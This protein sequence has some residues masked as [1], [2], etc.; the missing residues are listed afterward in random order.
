MSPYTYQIKNV[1]KNECIIVIKYISHNIESFAH[2]AL[3]LLIVSCF[4]SCQDEIPGIDALNH[5][6]IC[7]SINNKDLESRSNGADST[8]HQ[9]TSSRYAGYI[10]LQGESDSLFIHTTIEDEITEQ[11][12]LEEANTSE[13]A[14]ASR[15]TPI[16]S[17][18]TLNDFHVLAYW[19]KDE[20]LMST[21][22]MNDKITKSGALWSSTKSYYWPGTNHKL[23]FFAVAPEGADGLTLPTTP[24]STVLSY[25]VPNDV[26]KQQDLMFSTHDS[27]DGGYINGDYNAQVPLN[28][29]KH[30][31][32]AV[33]FSVGNIDGKIHSISIKGIRNKGT[34][35]MESTP[36]SEDWKWTLDETST[37]D[38]TLKLEYTIPDD[39]TEGTSITSDEK[40]LMM[41][42]QQL[43][44]EAKIEVIYTDKKYGIKRTL[45]ANI[46]N[47]NWEIG[48]YINYK[49]TSSE[50]LATPYFTATNPSQL[51]YTG[52]RSSYSVTSYIEVNGEKRATSWS[53]K[54]VRELNDGTY[55]T[56]NPG[57]NDYPTWIT[58]FDNKGNGSTT[59]LYY[60]V[61]IHA[62][63]AKAP[64]N[65]ILKITQPVSGTYNLSNSTG[66]ETVEKTAN[67]YIINAPGKYS[68]PLVYGNAIDKT[69]NPTYP[70]HNTSAY[71]STASGTK[72]LQTFINHANAPIT[73]P[74]IAENENCTP[75]DAILIWQ[76]AKDLI[77]TSSITL[78]GESARD[79]RINFEIPQTSICQGN[80]VI[81]VRNAN[82]EILWS[83]HI[84]VTDYTPFLTLTEDELIEEGLNGTYDPN[85]TQRD[86]KVWNYNNDHSF[87]FM[88]VPLGWCDGISY[89]GHQVLME[90]TQSISGL[91]QIITVKQNPHTQLGGGTFY[92]WGRKDPIIPTRGD[93]WNN[94]YYYDHNGTESAEI[95]T[96]KN[97]SEDGA[98]SWVADSTVIGKG[99]SHPNVYCTNSHM[100]KRYYNLWNSNN[101]SSSLSKNYTSTVKTIYDPS[102]VGY[103][104]PP[105]GAFDGFSYNG[106]YTENSF[107]TKFNS[108]YTSSDDFTKNIGWIFYCKGMGGV[109][110]NHDTTGGII[111]FPATGLRSYQTGRFS[112]SGKTNGHYWSTVP[113]SE[114]QSHNMNFT[115]TGVTLVNTASNR[116]FGYYIRP[117]Q[118]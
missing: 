54:F 90:L 92:E 111:Y 93:N 96:D 40:V 37:G 33:K 9:S 76:D 64:H 67:C 56:I 85:K 86:K 97:I 17:V 80:A 29:F 87:T 45:T 26:T 12:V 51:S 15:A 3:L 115:S 116:T 2:K 118:E 32:T 84:W 57:D 20:S 100:D 8:I 103:V 81:A 101:I 82:E 94:K 19:K 28:S 49:I 83:W 78:T 106:G 95:V 75:A 4:C 46:G 21:F 108:P 117:I 16:T 65:D 23:R 44:S 6:N 34:F 47:T 36:D 30:L 58:S 99:I 74:W 38:F 27:N 77:T 91:T 114:K 1:I 22:Y 104:I 11:S 13:Y 5:G 14:E 25:T 70:H 107:G 7:F 105:S 69:K 66:S 39:A 50:I 62:E 31:C 42:P 63:T 89:D 59:A 113:Y 35:D 73:S 18:N 61:T 53:A 71:T 112:G 48:K 98:T 88:G 102:P 24:T 10:L 110:S 72:V 68:F 43:P 79:Y 55:Q 41:L 60:Y 52:G 109:Q